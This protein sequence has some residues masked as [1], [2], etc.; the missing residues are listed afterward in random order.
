MHLFH[1][2]DEVASFYIPSR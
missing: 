2:H 1:I